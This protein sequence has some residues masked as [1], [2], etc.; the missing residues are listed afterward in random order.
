MQYELNY[1]S[2]IVVERS[3]GGARNQLAVVLQ[4]ET[5]HEVLY[6]SDKVVTIKS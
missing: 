2:G 5:C 6:V 3:Y 4:T 1:I